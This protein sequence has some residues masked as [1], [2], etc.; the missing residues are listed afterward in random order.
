MTLVWAF[1]VWLVAVGV[2][3]WLHR[4]MVLRGEAKP[5]Q[6]IWVILVTGL[7]WGVMLMYELS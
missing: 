3:A 4:R 7:V 1:A 6:W 5:I 2:F